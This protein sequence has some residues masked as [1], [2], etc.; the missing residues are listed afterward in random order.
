MGK[1]M[2]RVVNLSPERKGGKGKSKQLQTA[3][4]KPDREGGLYT[5]APANAQGAEKT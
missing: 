4:Q 5:Q 2:S 1:K 3:K